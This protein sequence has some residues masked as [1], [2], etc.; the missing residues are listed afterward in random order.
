[1]WAPVPLFLPTGN[2]WLIFQLI[3]DILT[4]FPWCDSPNSISTFGG[5]IFPWQILSWFLVN[6]PNFTGTSLP[7]R[8]IFFS[9]GP[10]PQHM[11]VP[12]QGVKSKLWLPAYTTATIMPEPSCICD[13][14]H[15]S[16]QGR[17]LNPLSEARDRTWVLMILI[18]FISVV[19]WRELPKI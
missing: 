8:F 13:L 19:P 9:L 1:M 4:L 11:E 18:R 2:S 5:V 15:S 16:W 6:L 3:M 12:R 17:I 14:H 7:L 10:H